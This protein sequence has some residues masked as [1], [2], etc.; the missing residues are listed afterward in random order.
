MLVLSVPQP[1]ASLIV[2]GYKTVELRNHHPRLSTGGFYTG[3]IGIHASKS[4]AGLEKAKQI[5]DLMDFIHSIEMDIEP[6]PRGAVIGECIIDKVIKN[7][8]SNNLKASCWSKNGSYTWHLKSACLYKNPIKAQGFVN[9]WNWEKPIDAIISKNCT[10]NN[11]D[12]A[13]K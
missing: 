4:L 9:L 6:L 2:L 7:D 3:H 12:T 11:S 8:L 5:Y 1:W 10:S 13:R